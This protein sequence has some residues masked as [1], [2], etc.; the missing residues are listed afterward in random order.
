MLVFDAGAGAMTQR[1][2]VTGDRPEPASLASVLAAADPPAYVDG[3][4]ERSGWIL[5]FV[6]TIGRE[7]SPLLLERESVDELGGYT[8]RI[9]A[10]VTAAA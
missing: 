7:G 3:T 8:L 10:T 1:S 9:E 6:D 4:G 5:G 2:I